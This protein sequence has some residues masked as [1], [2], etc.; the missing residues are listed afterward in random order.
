VE[1]PQR[2]YLPHDV[3]L[4]VNRDEEIYFIT[5]CCAD[6]GRNQI[7]NPQ[8]AAELFKSV[9]HRNERHDWF[10]HLFVVMPDHV[11][12]LLSFGPTAKSIKNT[13]KAW[14]HWTSYQLGI[15]WQRDFFEHR[16][17]HDE[18]R[19]EKADY[20]LRNPVR[21]GLVN[22]PHEWPY[23]WWPQGDNPLKLRSW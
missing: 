18:S 7:A 17:R 6:R 19:R 3:P 14:K 5:V 13:I 9:V 23:V 15:V 2:K 10:A 1:L 11:H 8:V 12:A 4:F 22:E 20:L 21:A 16:L